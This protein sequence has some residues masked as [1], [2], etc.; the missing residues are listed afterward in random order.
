MWTCSSQAPLAVLADKDGVVEV[1]G[2]LTVDGNDGQIA[3]IAAA[4]GFLLVQVGDRARLLE[5]IGR[6]NMGQMMLADDDFDV[7]TEV[8]FPAQNLD[9]PAARGTGG[10][11]PV[12][13][14]H[15]DHH[16]LQPGTVSND[17][18]ARPYSR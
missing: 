4:G 3:K 2:G 17:S 11:R 14:L 8:I 15:V 10:R 5:N 9:H 1:L 18:G 13:D 16:A 7:D 12:G 6:E